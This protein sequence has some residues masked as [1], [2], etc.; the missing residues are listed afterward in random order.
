M[1]RVLSPLLLLC[2]AI[3][4]PSSGQ[5]LSKPGPVVHVD[6][7]KAAL[8]LSAKEARTR[9]VIIDIRTPG[10]FREGH[11]KGAQL[12][13]FLG[14]DFSGKIAKLKRDRP[15]LVHCRSGGRSSQ[16][17]AIWKKLGFKRIYHLDGG[18]LDWQKA[19]LPVS[20]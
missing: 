16:S 20:K 10:E 13:D 5:A 18:M 9:P 15:Y 1:Q 14:D 17:L 11:L 2:L 12:I 3:S 6:A 19:G 8:L 7:K 4:L